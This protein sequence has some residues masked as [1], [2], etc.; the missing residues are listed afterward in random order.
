MQIGLFE[1]EP[2]CSQPDKG[3]VTNTVKF[4]LYFGFRIFNLP[5]F[6]QHCT[7][8]HI[9]NNVPLFAETQCQDETFEHE[10]KGKEK[11]LRLHSPFAS[12]CKIRQ[13]N[14]KK[15]TLLQCE[16]RTSPNVL[17]LC[18]VIVSAS[19]SLEEAVFYR[20]AAEALTQNRKVPF[21][22]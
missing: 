10:R 22:L 21:H 2:G 5:I 16:I 8:V 12:V 1:E 4:Y 9:F 17:V 15:V 11:V 13:K 19:W 20:N 18:P 14:C 6:D 7:F 3:A